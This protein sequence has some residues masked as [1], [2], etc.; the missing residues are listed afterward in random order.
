MKSRNPVL[1]TAIACAAMA[2]AA[3]ATGLAVGQPRAGL[4]L[5]IGLLLGSANGF[6][7]RLGVGLGGAFLATSMGRLVLLSTVGLGAGV[8]LG[9]DVAWWTLV[10]LA[11]AQFV[12]AL[13]AVRAVLS[14]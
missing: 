3:S 6:L 14:R 8:L 11:I 10:G 1:T 13:A 5:A 7:A 2:L 12:L 9:L 4:A